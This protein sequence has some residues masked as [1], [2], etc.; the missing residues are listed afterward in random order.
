MK[1]LLI[2]ICIVCSMFPLYFMNNKMESFLSDKSGVTEIFFD[3][4]V[5]SDSPDF[6]VVKNGEGSIVCA[7]LSGRNEILKN[8]KNCRGETVMLDKKLCDIESIKK[9]INFLKVCE[10]EIPNGGLSY[11]GFCDIGNST[12]SVLGKKVNVQIYENDKFILLGFPIILGG[13]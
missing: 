7:N 13:Y 4:F 3:Y 9:E 10:S 12:V 8:N 5:N 1:K 2:L 6:S 11:L